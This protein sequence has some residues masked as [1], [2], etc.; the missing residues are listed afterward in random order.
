MCQL[1][2]ESGSSKTN[3]VLLSPEGQEKAHYSSEGINPYYQSSQQIEQVIS[4]AFAQ[5]PEGLRHIWF[6]GAGCANEERNAV[7][8]EALLSFFGPCD[9][10]IASDLLAAARSLCQR[11]SGMVGILGTGSN[12]CLYDGNHIS[13]H[14]SPL[15]F[16]LGDEGSGAV[17]GRMLVADVLKNQ[18]PESIS[19]AFFEQYQLDASAIIDR[20]Y[21]Q[22]LPNRFLA[23]FTPFLAER[24][25]EPA[26]AELLGKAFDAFFR[27]NIHQYTDYHKLPLHLTGSI[28]WHFRHDLMESAGRNGVKLGRIL[29]DPLPGLI[30]YHRK[31][32][33]SH[34]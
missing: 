5:R 9:V 8:K 19:R 30:E 24:R 4:E 21:R 28:A 6:Y 13:H 20:V 25:K 27:R 3:W 1:I 26:L 7:V 18:L 12:S 17:L 22:S 34:G 31:L 23:G 32:P 33:C 16:I 2:A 29:A 10:N 14:V 11:E 15:G